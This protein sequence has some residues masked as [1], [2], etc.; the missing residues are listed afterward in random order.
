MKP[1]A[2]ITGIGGQDGSYLAEF[3]ISRGYEVHGLVRDSEDKPRP[4]LA[5]V[6]DQLTVHRAHLGD[7]VAVRALMVAVA[8]REVYHLAAQSHVAEAERDPGDTLRQNILGTLNLL[9]A[10][11]HMSVRPRFFH[12]STAQIFGQPIHQPQDEETPICPINRYGQSKAISTNLIRTWRED[13]RLYAVNG[14]LFNHESPRRG[15]GFVTTKIC[16]AA[17]AIAAGRQRGLKLGNLAAV[18][19]WGDAREFVVGFWQSLQAP[20]PGDYVFATGKL[21]SVQD[22]LDIAFESVN[23]DWRDHVVLDEELLR[24]SDPHQLVGNPAKAARE[25]GWVARKPFAELIREMVAAA[26]RGPCI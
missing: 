8:P 7:H 5:A 24:K 17:A 18:R 22:L 9:E 16:Q 25:L 3:L 26:A 10:A 19:D 11:G 13:F 4:H 20:S 23:L 12:A 15:S 1:R 21:H 6:A 14:I 2:L